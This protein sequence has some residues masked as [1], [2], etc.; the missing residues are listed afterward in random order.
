MNR[1]H[2]DIIIAWANGEDIQFKDMEGVWADYVTCCFSGYLNFRIKP[3]VQDSPE[4][5]RQNK[6]GALREQI[7]NLEM[8]E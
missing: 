2:K 8:M 4:Q 6:I 5:I 1:T 7:A 3:D